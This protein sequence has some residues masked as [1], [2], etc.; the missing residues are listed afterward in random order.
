MAIQE[1]RVY[2]AGLAANALA[3]ANFLK[4]IGDSINRSNSEGA[5]NEAMFSQ[6]RTHSVTIERAIEEFL[7]RSAR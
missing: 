3:K 2:Y 4:Q 7:A 5:K 1:L 6:F